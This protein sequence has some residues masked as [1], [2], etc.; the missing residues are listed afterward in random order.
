MF[1]EYY[2]ELF[3]KLFLLKDFPLFSVSQGVFSG[4]KV[5][6]SEKHDKV[7]EDG[8]ESLTAVRS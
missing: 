8:S 3:T 7:S 5:E 4:K 1:S 2:S 6:N